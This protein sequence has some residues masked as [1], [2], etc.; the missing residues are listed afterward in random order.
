MLMYDECF[1]CIKILHFNLKIKFNFE[2]Y[3]NLVMSMFNTH[4][5]YLY[6]DS[7]FVYNISSNDT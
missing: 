5:I 3:V 7:I 1:L 2:I 6:V 4:I